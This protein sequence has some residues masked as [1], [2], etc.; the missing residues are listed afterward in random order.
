VLPQREL[1][2]Q[3]DPSWPQE[4]VFQH[5]WARLK[6]LRKGSAK[7]SAFVDFRE[8]NRTIEVQLRANLP[9]LIGELE[10]IYAW[11]ATNAA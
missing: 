3:I 4:R 9:H 10:A 8:A 11:A 6:T 7:A 5:Y 2:L 1:V